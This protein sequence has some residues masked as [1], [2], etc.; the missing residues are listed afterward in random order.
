MFGSLIKWYNI[1][2]RNLPWRETSDPY[3]IWLS[4]VVLQQTRV[5]QG[6]AYYYKF[7]EHYPTVFKLASAPIDDVL[8]LWQGLGYYSRARNLHKAARYLVGQFQGKFPEDFAELKKIPGVGNYTAAAIASLAFKL[9]V[10][11]VDGNVYRVLS[12]VFEIAEPIDST[13]GKNIFEKLAN[14]V[15]D[16]NKPDI[17]NQAM[18]ELGALICKPRAPLCDE[19]PVSH[20]CGALKNRSQHYYPVKKVKGR[21]RERYFYYCIVTSADKIFIEKRNGND[22]WKGLFQFPL[23]ES[24]RMFSESEIIENINGDCGLSG[25]GFKVEKISGKQKHVLSHQIIYACFVHMQC[26]GQ[27]NFSEKFQAVQINELQNYAFPRLITR[28]L[29]NEKILK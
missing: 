1:A 4:E 16:K 21:Q 17:H 3:K 15:L 14:E 8:L 22:I 23:I 29:E 12:R 25:P 27:K 2:A 9:P 7:I 28:Y 26:P 10:A 5:E 6:M 20:Q 13:K 24:N 19:C 18:M 11:V